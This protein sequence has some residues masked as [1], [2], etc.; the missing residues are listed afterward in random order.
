MFR[1]KI[2]TDEK[3]NTEYGTNKIIFKGAKAAKNA[4]VVQPREHN[5]ETQ[6]IAPAE[7]KCTP[8]VL[9]EIY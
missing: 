1:V 6:Q 5:K 7:P 8:E 4:K 2:D 3:L 9:F